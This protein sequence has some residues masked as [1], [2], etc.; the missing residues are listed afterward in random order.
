MSNYWNGISKYKNRNEIKPWFLDEY[1]SLC[2]FCF[3]LDVLW[4]PKYDA[5]AMYYECLIITLP[6]GIQLVPHGRWI[7]PIL[8]ERWQGERG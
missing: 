4:L 8:I 3:M 1:I 6:L 2:P 7:R 5:F